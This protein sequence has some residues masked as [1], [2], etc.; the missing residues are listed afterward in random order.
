MAFWKSLVGQYCVELVSSDIGQMLSAINSEGIVLQQV[1]FVDELH[2]RTT[3]SRTQFPGLK[4]IITKRGEEL[5]IQKRKGI[6]WKLCSLKKRPVLVLGL[7]FVLMLCLLIPSR[8]LF[9]E[10][11]GNSK[12]PGNYII[13]TAKKCGLDIFASRR[14]VRS[15]KIKNTLLS[16]IPQLQWVGVNTS[17]CIARISVREREEQPQNEAYPLA[18]SVIT[19]RD[20]I[21]QEITVLSGTPLCKVGQGVKAG[22][23]LVSGYTDCGLVIKLQQA[24]AEVFAYT[25]RDVEAVTPGKILKRTAEQSKKRKIMLRIGKNII[26]LWKD[27]GIS[28]TRCVK[29]YSEEHLTLPGGFQLP[30]ALITEYSLDY[31][32][33]EEEIE[34]PDWLGASTEEYLQSCMIAGK[35]FQKNSVI[36]DEDSLC[37]LRGRYVC[38]EMIGQKRYEENLIQN[39]T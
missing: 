4:Q 30:V 31:L 8:I 35:I 12:I 6:F 39:G 21:I 26:N 28:D 24:D 23:V 33:S 9:V 32:L 3:I 20:G 11:S 38:L 16:E 5:N 1:Q 22:D 27:S 13:E 25:F 17:G 34:P 7:L 19:E 10:V 15:E 14:E 29:M 37:V 36:T 18:S 2:L